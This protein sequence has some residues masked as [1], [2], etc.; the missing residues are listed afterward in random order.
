MFSKDKVKEIKQEFWN[1][2]KKYCKNKHVNR[3]WLLNHISV[4]CSQLKFD[5]N[6]KN[7]IVGIQVDDKK[8]EKKHLIFSYWKAY[9]MLI[10]DSMGEELIWNND[11]ISSDNRFVCMAYTKLEDVD[12]LKIEDHERIYDFFIEKM[13]L[14]ENTYEEIGDSIKEGI[15]N[16]S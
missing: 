4:E 1:G 14:L 6:R 5:V 3:R 2:F 9:K 13:I 16:K 7:A 8:I 10:E 11:Y 12:I 15:K